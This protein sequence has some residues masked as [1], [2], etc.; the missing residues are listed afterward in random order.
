MKKN[1]LIA[2]V[3]IMAVM[4][5]AFALNGQRYPSVIDVSLMNQI[6]DPVGP[7]EV[8]EL[9]FRV[10]NSGE[11][12]ATDVVME[13]VPEYPFS[14]RPGDEAKKS[15]GSLQ[16]KA[17]DDDGVTL[18]YKVIVDKNAPDGFHDIRLRYKDS[19]HT[20]W[21][22][23][24]AFSI[25]VQSHIAIIGI[26]KVTSNPTSF[27]PGDKAR[28]SLDLKNFA[29]S[30]LKDIIVKLDLSA[31]DL[32][33]FGSSNERVISSIAAQQSEK[34][35]FDLIADPDAVAGIV[36][37]PVFISYSDVTGMN[38]T[39]SNTISLMIGGVPDI[40][41]T[42]DGTDI[43]TEDSVGDAVIKVVNRGTTDVK[44]MTVS[45]GAIE[46][47][48]VV[49]SSESYIGNLDSDDFSTAEFKLMVKDAKESVFL[50]VTVEYKDANNNNYKKEADLALKLYSSNEAKKITGS[51]NG[52]LIWV[53]AAVL[54]IAGFF[55]YR[56]WKKH[57]Q[58]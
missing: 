58:K 33:P 6:P 43:Y 23:L 28:I 41:I 25:K 52:S 27:E 32:S 21:I 47:A 26:S 46:G 39:K 31:T 49:G 2:V 12:A 10:E 18:R 48:E 9:N 35:E 4:P 37:I 44:F 54:A 53:I 38:Y 24:D 55:L 7:G 5:L 36:K 51:G 45:V 1:V 14:L 19:E 13:L 3:L 57:K 40:A 42:L 50:P 8:A 20:E 17:L 56:R 22:L 29:S 34:A 30:H 15:I 16:S 11:R